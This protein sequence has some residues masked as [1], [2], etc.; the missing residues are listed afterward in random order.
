M[1]GSEAWTWQRREQCG[2]QNVR[3]GRC[4][5]WLCLNGCHLVLLWWK[6]NSIYEV[7]VY[8]FL[9]VTL[10][11]KISCFV[12]QRAYAFMYR[13][14]IEE[15][16]FYTIAI[17]H[18]ASIVL[19]SKRK[20]CFIIISFFK[21]VECLMFASSFPQCCKTTLPSLIRRDNWLCYKQY[22]SV[23]FSF[24][25][26]FCYCSDWRQRFLKKLSLLRC[27]FASCFVALSLDVNL[28]V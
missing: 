11:M 12:Q 23:F 9:Y 28:I 24:S 27:S 17:N 4:W 22:I 7:T 6:Q 25:C 20:M 16:L 19:H 8:L 13:S 2:C 3:C 1:R 14:M 15:H 10:K 18:A 26:L 5:I 21:H